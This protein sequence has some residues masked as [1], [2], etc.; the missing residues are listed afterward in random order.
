MLHVLDALLPFH[1]DFIVFAC[2]LLSNGEK[3]CKSAEVIS[4]IAIKLPWNLQCNGIA[5]SNRILG[6]CPEVDFLS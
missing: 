6:Y 1:W 5:H 2:M 4:I 3:M